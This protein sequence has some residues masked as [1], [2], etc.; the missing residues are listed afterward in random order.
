MLTARER[1]I[2]DLASTGRTS[3]E[4]AKVLFLSVRTVDRHLG[5]VYR[6]LGVSNRTSL[7]HA[8]LNNGAPDA[9]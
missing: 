4:I 1:E 8:M 9:P 7:N 6:K 5:R 3:N 2:A